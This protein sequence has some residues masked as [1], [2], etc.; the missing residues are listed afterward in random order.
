MF[1]KTLEWHEMETTTI[2]LKSLAEEYFTICKLEG[3]TQKT[4]DGYLEKIMRFVNAIDGTLEDFTLSN[5]R[6]YIGMLQQ[7]KK[8]QGHPGKMEKDELLSATTVSNHVRTLKGFSSWLKRDDYTQTNVMGKIRTPKCPKKIMKTLTPEEIN[9][10]LAILDRN[11]ATGSRA[12]AIF[13]LFLDSGL[14]LSELLGLKMDDLHIEDNWLKV[15]GKGQ[16]ERVVPF[17]Y[18]T[19]RLIQRYILH[20]RPRSNGFDNVF[21]NTF[22]E[23]MGNRAVISMFSRIAQKADVPRLHVHL[24]RHTFATSYLISGGD[25]LTL[26]RIFGHES[27]EMTRRYVDQ[28]ASQVTV[29]NSRFSPVDRLAAQRGR[30]GRSYIS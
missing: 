23:P 5:V 29:L 15:M 25:S 16:K 11:T 28:V 8:W 9:R 12:A 2:P 17:G 4:I 10:I 19:A 22:G 20:F 6:A 13:C 1:K 21:L 30:N 24:L 7:T 3:K 27:L 26:Q 18:R 14:Q